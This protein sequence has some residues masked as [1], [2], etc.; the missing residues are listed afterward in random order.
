MH[1]RSRFFCG[2]ILF[3]I[4]PFLFFP[5]GSV[6]AGDPS[7][8]PATESSEK[9]NKKAVE[10][11]RKM[12]PEEIKALDKKLADA[13]ILYY[14]RKFGQALPIFKEIAGQ[15]ETM[16]I[17]WWLGTSAMRV[18]ETQLAIVKF[19]EML[20]INP[21]LHRVR[22]DLALAYFNL[23]RYDEAKK[24]IS[25][26]E[27][28]KPPEAVQKNIEKLLASIE[29]RTKKLSWNIR[30]SQGIM[31]DTNVSAGPNERELEVSGGTLTLGA[32]SKKVRDEALVT[33]LQGNVL[34]DFGKHQEFMW[35]TGAVFY[36]SA[37]QTYSKYNFMMVDINT[38]PWWVGRR[39]IIKVP[40]GYREQYYGSERLSNI[41]HVDPSYEHYFCRYFSL[42]ALYSYNK[43][44]FYSEDNA[45]LENN[46]HVYELSPSIYL[47]NRRHIISG[48]LGYENRDADTRRFCYSGY[49]YAIS[50]FTRFPTNTE[51]FFRY[52]W[53]EKDYKDKP[54]LYTEN[55]ED[56]RHTITAVISQQFYKHFFAS[57]AFYYT[58]NHSNAGL[59]EFDKA[60]YTFNIGLTF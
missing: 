18:G 3:F 2:I 45:S 35:N 41:I 13:L 37:Y 12:T 26:V 33:S 44:F 30:F 34:Y 5:S 36:N 27:A 60:T 57:L 25:M 54:L 53:M 10:K 55:R 11:L 59:Y 6:N 42:R 8:S 56:R 29:Q 4:F 21:A 48:S 7:G 24:E 14:D 38:G 23:G 32:D 20:E 19:K 52:K 47:D 1:F 17:M 46:T 49:Y 50:Y 58:D 43:E 39:D 22:L 9:V 15:V 28:A 51:F 31:Y 16:D 40:V